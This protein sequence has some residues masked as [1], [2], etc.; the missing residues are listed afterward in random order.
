MGVTPAP[1]TGQE[2]TAVMPL[3]EVALLPQ[4]KQALGR[5]KA[6]TADLGAAL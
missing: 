1:E 6:P 3:L 5:S 2:Q 4:H